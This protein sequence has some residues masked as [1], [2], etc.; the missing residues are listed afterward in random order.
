MPPQELLE[1]RQRDGVVD[2]ADPGLVSRAKGGDLDALGQL[3]DQNQEGIYRY[4]LSRVRDPHTAEDLTGDVFA[5]MLTALPGYRSLG[6]P[7]RSWL[8]QIARN[9]LIDH[10]RRQGL[11]TLTG[12][13]GDGD[14]NDGGDIAAEVERSMTAERIY[15]ALDSLEDSQR[16]VVALRFLSGLSLKEVA[17]TLKKSVAATKSIQHRGLSALRID[18]ANER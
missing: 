5:K 15:V 10:Y 8:Y 2:G 1:R 12:L 11:R 14:P 17:R 6:V 3:Y 13:E 9:L 16:E 7:F 18:L 4:I